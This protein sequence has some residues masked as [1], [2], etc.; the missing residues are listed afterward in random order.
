[1]A[2][3]DGHRQRLKNRFRK[4]GLDNFDERYVLELLLFYCIPRQDTKPLA[5]R[6]LEHFGSIVDVLDATPEELEKVEGVGEGVSTFLAL[7]SA[8]ERYYQM[9]REELNLDIASNILNTPDAYCAF[10][11]PYF[12][13]QRNE[14]VY[15]L[16]LDAQCKFMCCRMVGEGS[17]N[18]ANVPIRRLVEMALNVNASFVVIAHNHPSGLVLP[19]KEDIQTTIRVAKAMQAVDI[20]LVDHVIFFEKESISLAQSGT[21]NYRDIIV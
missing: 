21:Y 12:K 13:G 10:L 6:L 11:A 17:V 18:S 7:R 4:E 3:Q 2:M 9:K 5:C 16:C 19:S 1:M 20:A 15:I 14:V 8:V